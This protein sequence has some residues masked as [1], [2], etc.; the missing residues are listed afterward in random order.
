MKRLI[1]FSIFLTW[2]FLLFAK[3]VSADTIT[4]GESA[5]IKL[6]SQSVSKLPDQRTIMLKQYLLNHNS[7]LA[8]YAKFLIQKSD[9]YQLFDWRLLPAIAGVESTF[10]KFMPDN[11]YN[12]WGWANGNYVFSSWEDAIDEVSKTLK[13]KYINR[14]LNTVDKIAPVYAPPSSAW[15]GKVKYFIE[16]IS[17]SHSTKQLDLNI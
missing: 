17:L 7:P 4:A 8:I 12:A 10:G 9:Q 3:A 11:S 15:A 6:T 2:L 5:R 1:I 16:Q 13:E 14:G